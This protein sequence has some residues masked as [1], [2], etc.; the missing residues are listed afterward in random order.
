MENFAVT[1]DAFLRELYTCCPRAKYITCQAVDY[2]LDIC[3]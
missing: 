3:V 1:I 2:S